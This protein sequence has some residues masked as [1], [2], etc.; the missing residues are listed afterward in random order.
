MIRIARVWLACAAAAAAGGCLER[1]LTI[2]TEPSEAKVYL[3]H[4]RMTETTPDGDRLQETPLTETFR[5]YGPRTVQIEKDGYRT[6]DTE[7]YV[8][9]PF[10]EF[11]GIDLLSAILCPFTIHDR[12]EFVFKLE[13]LPEGTEADVDALLTRAGRLRA[14]GAKMRTWRW[15]PEVKPKAKPKPAVKPPETPAAPSPE[16]TEDK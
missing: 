5:Y 13:P 12:N 16:S 7:I 15:Q 8:R 11:P 1:T 14:Q 2:R 4:K 3:D 6:L 9:L 10:Y